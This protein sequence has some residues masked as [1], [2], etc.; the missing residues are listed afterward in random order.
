MNNKEVAHLWAN[1]SRERA[2][3]SHFYF[4]GDTIYSYGSHFPIARHHKG[5]ALFTNGTRSNTTARHISI[6]RQAA[7]HLTKFHVEDPTKNP[8]RA[9][10][11]SYAERVKDLS[12]RTARARNPDNHLNFLQSVVD[13][14]NAFC[15]RFGFKTR[16]SMPSNLDELKAKAAASAERERAARAKAKAKLEADQAE[17]ITRWI[18]GEAVQI[19]WNISRVYLRNRDGIIE[20][21]K[22]AKVALDAA[23]QAY[24]F[25]RINRI[26]G[27]RRNG[28]TFK[29][30]DYQLDSV[31]EQGIIAGCHRIDWEEIERFATTQ[32][33]T[34]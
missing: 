4:E 29:V 27:W 17:T 7:S 8:G 26:K 16:F 15:T 31:N 9:D 28:D 5:V 19:S 3:G 18:A 33:W 30:G 23:L 2:S 6:T 25:A 14:G 22:G 12:M 34:P 1:R 13:E 11:L 10:V 20:T 21:S 32:G 24:R